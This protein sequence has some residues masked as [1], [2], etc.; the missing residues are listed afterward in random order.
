LFT[1]TR[2]EDREE[3]FVK[4]LQQCCVIF[5]FV[6]DPLS[7]LKWKEVKRTAL[8]ELVDYVSQNRGVITEPIYQTACHMVS[9]KQPCSQALRSF[10]GLVSMLTYFSM[11]GADKDYIPMF[12]WTNLFLAVLRLNDKVIL[13][14]TKHKT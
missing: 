11:S 5:D 4:K 12:S 1:D 14:P 10:N 3:L 7:D 9:I 2:P 13:N 8:Y 6:S